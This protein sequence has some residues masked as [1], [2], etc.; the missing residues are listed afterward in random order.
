MS[1]FDAAK[2]I[3]ALAPALDLT[4]AAGHRPGVLMHLEAAH[5]A[6]E[7]MRRVPLDDHAEPAPVFRPEPAGE[8]PA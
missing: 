4:V 8:G 3:D 7:R 1:D 5:T 2:L 6:L